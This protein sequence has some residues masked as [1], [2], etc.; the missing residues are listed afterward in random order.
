MRTNITVK[1]EGLGE[2]RHEMAGKDESIP[3]L[4][5]GPVEVVFYDFMLARD[6]AVCWLIDLQEHAR[7]LADQIAAKW[8]AED[9]EP[10]ELE[11]ARS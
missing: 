1:P 5:I 10:A 7:L 3:Q 4:F 6:E 8:P 2:I 11:A 9:T